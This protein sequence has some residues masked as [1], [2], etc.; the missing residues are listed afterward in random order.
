MMDAYFP[1][2]ENNGGWRKN[3]DRD[4]LRS[5]GMDAD[6]LAKF[7]KYNLSLLDRSGQ[8]S[9]IV[10]KDGWIVGE[11][12]SKP[13]TSTFYQYLSSNGKSYA[14]ILFGMIVE[15]SRS[16]KLAYSI[17]AD[18]RAYDEGWLPEGSPLS[19]P[20]KSQIAFEH[21][22]NHTSGI[23]PESAEGPGHSGDV[24]F[25]LYNVGR[26]PRN[27]KS[28]QLFFDPGHPEQYAKDPYSS[29]AFNHIGMIVPHLTGMKASHY[30]W[31]RLMNPLGF[32]GVVWHTP[33]WNA[34]D[35]GIEWYS[36][37]SP[38]IIPRDYA[39]IAY[40]FL[41]DGKWGEDQLVP[42]S[43]IQRFRTSPDYANIRS[44]VDGCFGDRYPRDLFRIAGS[45]M[46]WAFMIPSLDLIA[47]RTSRC[48][49]AWDE[50]TPIFLE[51]L[52]DSLL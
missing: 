52:F 48:Y 33:Y 25:T 5:L 30:L 37:S 38:K 7:G 50:H 44:N 14:V 35:S 11:W 26:D 23:L 17:D 36:S 47:I 29:I 27:E 4:F 21:I 31:D 32:S 18:S 45:G 10:I 13:E 24:D 1:P 8:T 16:G 42:A 2:S 12:Y 34:G 20:R 9:C 41:R 51:K 46:N 6:K 3:T 15:D 28:A 19:D 49:L 40:L 43:W 39:R 22:F